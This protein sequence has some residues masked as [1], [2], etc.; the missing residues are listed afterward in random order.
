M[1]IG[2]DGGGTRTRAVLVTAAGNVAGVG[3][4]GPSNQHNVGLEVAVANLRAA[5]RDAWRAAGAEFR[6]ADGAF[7]GCAGVK[8]AADAAR[9]VSG[10]VAAGFAPAGR[11]VV[12]NDLYNALAGGLEGRPGIALIAGTGTNCLG[13]DPAGNVHMCGGWGWLIDDEGGGCGLA[14]AALRAVARMADGRGRRTALE[15]PVLKFFGVGEPNELLARL[16]TQPWTADELAAF[17]PVVTSLAAQG[18]K[19]AGMI[20][21]AGAR[22][23]A[24]LVQGAADALVYPNGPDVVL[25]GSCAR[26]GPPYQP[27][28]EAA[29][30]RACPAARLVDPLASS[31]HGAALNAL[32]AAGV[33]PLPRPIW[34]QPGKIS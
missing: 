17:A 23:L 5:A 4:A 6:V 1:F 32:R 21:E 19:V 30:R 13:R 18:D 33:M 28:I 26:S 3:A 22:S 34:P 10:A 8:S 2:I 25:L 12:D 31:L 7:L 11:T 20:L 29:I 15:S 27:L 16:Y 24:A 9:V 14:L